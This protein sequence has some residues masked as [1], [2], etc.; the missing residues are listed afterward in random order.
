MGSGVEL[1]ES[2]TSSRARIETV[3]SILSAVAKK[4]VVISDK[5]TENFDSGNTGISSKPPCHQQTASVPLR[6]TLV[7]Y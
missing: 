3:D 2:T 6:C 1:S 4:R 7:D 5:G